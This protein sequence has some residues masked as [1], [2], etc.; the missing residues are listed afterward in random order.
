[1]LLRYFYDEKLAHAS[2]LVGCQA[3]GES[4]VI[5]P[6]RDVLPYLETAQ[7]EGLTVVAAAETHIHADFISGVREIGEEHKAMLYVSGEGGPDWSYA[8]MS[9][10]VKHRIVKDG[11][12]FHVGRI[13]FEVLHTPGH[14]PE[15]VSFLLTDRGGGA[16]CPMGI[17]T[18]DF[19]FVGDVG[20]PDLLEK[21]VGLA[22]T[23]V[24]GAR[25]MFQS[26]QRFT[27]LPEYAQVW[28]AH[29]AGS[30]CG[31]ALGAI[32]SSTVGYEK[33]FNWGF[34]FDA[35]SAF[36]TA[37]L[38]GQPEPPTYFPRMK[39]MNREGPALLSHLPE[40]KRIEGTIAAAAGL[41]ERGAVIID[42]RPCTGFAAGHVKGTINLPYNRS[43]TSWAGWLIEDERPLY[44]MGEAELLPGIVR[45]MRS[46]GIDR[47]EG[48]I[49][50]SA[51]WRDT[52]AAMA[53]L[54]SYPEVTPKDIAGKV[55]GG[56]L[57]VVD[58][59][60]GAEWEEGHI[61]GAQHILLGKL[62]ERIHEVPTDKPVLVQCRTGG[63]S[64]IAASI[65]QAHGYTNVMNL[66]GGIVQWSE[67]GLPIIK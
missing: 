37:L 6:A 61:P 39:R 3:T 2:Y 46:I 7:A 18:G 45:D 21:A 54:Q 57:T 14:T 12:R 33:R 65:L 47:I 59:R 67:E 36:T 48:I 13:E 4:I 52:H 40:P 9:D 64:A 30:A 60:S 34:S 25:Q 5:D 29:G 28:P 10:K 20:R 51:M 41:V 16:D 11:D 38:A 19:V 63:R 23:A 55:Q 26:L 35:E 58:V 17:F 50:T 31:K 24:Q 22:G 49:E 53:G 15:S 43:F 27:E 56:E 8:F 42:T 44:I 1:M 62:P 66:Q 32:P